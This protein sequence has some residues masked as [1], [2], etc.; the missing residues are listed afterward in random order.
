MLYRSGNQPGKDRTSSLAL[1]AAWLKAAAGVKVISNKRK[2]SVINQIL[3][4][5]ETRRWRSTVGGT[6]QSVQPTHPC[7]WK[8]KRAT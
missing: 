8:R 2:S 5:V 6:E 4:R 1:I 7:S 3:A